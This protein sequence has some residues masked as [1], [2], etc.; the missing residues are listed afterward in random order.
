MKTWIKRVLKGVRIAIIGIPLLL[1]ALIILMEIV[2]YFANHSA[3]DKQTKELKKVISLEIDD[4][5]II[6]EYSETGNTSGTG[7]HVD[8]LSRISFSSGMNYEVISDIFDKYYKYWELKNENGIYIVTVNTSAPF[9][10][11]IEGH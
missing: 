1:I 3:T 11:N 10:D 2:G 8:C 9:P 4:A 7:N 6:D 5:Q